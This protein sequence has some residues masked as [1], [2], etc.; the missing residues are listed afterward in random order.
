MDDLEGDS[1]GSHFEDGVIGEV[2]EVVL[3][4]A[5]VTDI[6]HPLPIL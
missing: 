6:P 3:V 5:R 4:S 1:V 2:L